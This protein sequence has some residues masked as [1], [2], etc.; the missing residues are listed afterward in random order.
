MYLGLNQPY[1][2]HGSPKKKLMW[3]QLI[4]GLMS[5]SWKEIL[6]GAKTSVCQSWRN[7]LPSSGL[8]PFRNE[9]GELWS[10][11]APGCSVFQ[12]WHIFDQDFFFKVY[13]SENTG[14]SF[15]RCTPWTFGFQEVLLRFCKWLINF[16]LER[17]YFKM[18][19][20]WENSHL[21]V[22]CM[23]QHIGNLCGQMPSPPIFV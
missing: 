1:S 8:P 11:K 5:V 15:S 16:R 2:L 13:Q 6:P 9:E 18:I 3:T 20:R 23:W 17:V 21:I 12:A 10:L 7:R 22:L 19:L 14:Q 4:H